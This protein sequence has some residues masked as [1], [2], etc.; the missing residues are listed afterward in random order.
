MAG[1]NMYHGAFCHAVVVEEVVVT[2]LPTCIYKNM[3][4][5]RISVGLM[6]NCFGMTWAARERN[7]TMDRRG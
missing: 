4:G 6:H 2:H 3:I 7:G 1:D 5:G